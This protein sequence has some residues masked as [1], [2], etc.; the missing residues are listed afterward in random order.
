MQNDVV[1]W[2]APGQN[3]IAAW[4]MQNA[5]AGW[6]H[7]HSSIVVVEHIPAEKGHE[8]D[9]SATA[10]EEDTGESSAETDGDD[11]GSTDDNEQ[12]VDEEIKPPS[13]DEIIRQKL[14]IRAYHLPG[15]S[16]CEDLCSY[17]QNNHL[18]FGLCCHHRLHPVKNKHRLILLLGS[19]AF[20]LTVTNV[21]FLWGEAFEDTG[22]E[23][24]VESWGG[25]LYNET[26]KYVPLD[27]EINVA[28]RDVGFDPSQIGI[29]WTLGSG[30]H[31]FFDFGLWHM[32]SCGYCRRDQTVGWVIAVSVV[33]VV[34]CAT[35]VLVYFR[36]FEPGDGAQQSFLGIDTALNYA[37]EET[38]DLYF[39][40]V[41]L[42]EILL[43]IFVY[44][45][46]VQ[47]VL[48][49]DSRLLWQVAVSGRQAAQCQ[50]CTKG[51]AGTEG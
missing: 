47:F 27:E 8:S 14:S 39:L 48:H 23:D 34:V 1:V 18:V 20:G 37:S 50:V 9:A 46:I 17:Y 44:T 5:A 40:L 30:I 3:A 28:G 43:S 36:V 29:L 7:S 32:I 12:P 2:S 22:I 42:I 49:R 19:L 15:N 6:N 21:I 51:R 16:W 31:S 38:P 4:H 26:E 10:S 35:T 25:K 33:M 45:P 13:E 41:Y 24:T 11:R